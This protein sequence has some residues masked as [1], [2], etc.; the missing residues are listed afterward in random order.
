MR[1]R[2]LNALNHKEDA[3]PLD[4]GSTAVTGL[5]VT[6]IAA[7]RDYYGLEK[8][9]VKVCE[10][11]QM[12]G[13]VEEDLIEALG[14]DTAGVIPRNTLFG[15]P[16]EN[17]KEW[18]APWG[19]ELLVAEKFNTIIKD[20]DVY[21]Y[22]E[23]D[24]TVP[25]S[26][27]MPDGGFFFDTIVRQE[28]VDD[29]NLNPEDNLE[30]FGLISEEDLRYFEKEVDAANKTGRGVIAN[31]GGTAFG[32]IALVPAPFLKNPKGIR[33]ITEWY[34][35][36]AMRQDYIHKVFE[37]QLEYALENLKAIY[38]VIG[39]KVDAV[40]LCGTDFG[41]QTG[42]FCAPSTF[43]ELWAPY[44][45]KMNTWIHENTTWKTFKHSCGAV[46]SFM[47]HF[48][49]TGWD[50]I[51]PV[52]CSATGMEPQLLKNKYGAELTF[53]GGAIDTQHT[54]PFGSPEEV[55][56][57]AL[58]RCEIF[59]KNGGFVFNP[60]HNVQANTPVENIVAMIDALNTFNGNK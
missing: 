30:E 54:L 5:H 17:W 48:I 49:E 38:K 51:N 53:W 52:Q 56:K 14:V 60:V 41:T 47:S 36:T 27:H 32:D 13:E 19:Q 37:K 10:P 18:K 12:L 42:T 35:S 16:N 24:S 39:N 8:K 44:Y 23:G 40:F 28:P 59:G 9:P 50:I 22:P 55:K 7:L 20:N 6:C 34:M 3:I 15:F 46:E 57:E 26:G 43:D 33:D 11:Y 2:L 21:I 4:L 29:T 45:K 58:S 25:P 1:K 31:F